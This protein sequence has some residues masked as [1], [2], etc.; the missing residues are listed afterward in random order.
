MFL[1]T[2]LSFAS[3]TL[4]AYMRSNTAVGSFLDNGFNPETVLPLLFKRKDQ[5]GEIW[6]FL[7]H[8]K[9]GIMKN[10]RYRIEFNLPKGVSGANVNDVNQF[11]RTGAIQTA[12]ALYNRN[13]SIAIKA[14]TVT[15]PQRAFQ[16]FELKQNS[17]PF[18][19]PLTTA[20]DPITFS[21]YSDAKMDVRN[22]FDLWQSAIIN[23]SNNTCNF[24]NEYVSDIK[25]YIQN[26]HN[27]DVY[28]IRLIDCWVMGQSIIDASYS[29]SNQFMN[30][31]V[32]FS[33]KYWLPLSSTQRRSSSA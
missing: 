32:T 9:S 29:S 31:A 20:Y 1:S 7:S 23:Y 3:D 21:F 16:T 17:A 8:F 18:R 12:E 33:Y 25:M 4:F 26:D 10:N 28:G 24:Y 19:I 11:A 30:I 2:L 6:D 5:G 14:H 13:N 22:Y 27:E 15:F